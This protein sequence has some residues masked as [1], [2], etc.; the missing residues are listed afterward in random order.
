MG[1]HISKNLNWTENT[2][3]QSKNLWTTGLIVDTQQ[4]ILCLKY[5]LFCKLNAA[6]L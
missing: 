2:V 1:T 6:W 3:A 5:V 4:N